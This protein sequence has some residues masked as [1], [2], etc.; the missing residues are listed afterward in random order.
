MIALAPGS[1][2]LVGWGFLGTHAKKLCNIIF[3][4]HVCVLLVKAIPMIYICYIKQGRNV[5]ICDTSLE[6]AMCHVR[7]CF[8]W[9]HVDEQVC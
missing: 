9:D 8:L 1:G 4:H 7:E 3:Y 5:V 2:H 6:A